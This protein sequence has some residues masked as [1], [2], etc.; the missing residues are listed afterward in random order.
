MTMFHEIL[1]L[2]WTMKKVRKERK[3]ALINTIHK[4][5]D[6]TSCYNYREISL[7]TVAGNKEEIDGGRWGIGSLQENSAESS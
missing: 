1:I 6:T 5:G 2:A 3:L 7:L 4:R